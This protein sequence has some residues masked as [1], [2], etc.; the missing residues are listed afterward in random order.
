MSSP[1]PAAAQS[2]CAGLT[3]AVAGEAD[4]AGNAGAAAEVAVGAAVGADGV[5][6]AGVTAAAATGV[7]FLGTLVAWV[8]PVVSA[9]DVLGVPLATRL[10]AVPLEFCTRALAGGVCVL[11]CVRALAAPGAEAAAEV[12]AC[13]EVEAVAEVVPRE[14]P[15][16]SATGGC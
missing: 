12:E 16:V 5:A 3:A 10:V 11:V 8:V 6:T 7:S 2:A 14:E 15:I 4:G 1:E 9:G 13:E